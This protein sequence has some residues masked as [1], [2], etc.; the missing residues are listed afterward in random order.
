MPIITVEDEAGS[1]VTKNIRNGS[2]C[3][4][5]LIVQKKNIKKSR[6]YVYLSTPALQNGHHGNHP[7]YIALCFS[8][9]L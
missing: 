2:G 7:A 5:H 9:H 1:Q 8:Y 6:A 4:E 3:A